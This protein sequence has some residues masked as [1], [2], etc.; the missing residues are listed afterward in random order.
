MRPDESFFIRLH[1]EDCKSHELTTAGF[2]NTTA[3]YCSLH[4][5]HYVVRFLT[6]GLSSAR[7][8][9]SHCLGAFS[10]CEIRAGQSKARLLKFHRPSF[11][12][13]ANQTAKLAAPSHRTLPGLEILQHS[14]K[15][16][17]FFFSASIPRT[18]HRTA[19]R[20]WLFRLKTAQRG[21]TNRTATAL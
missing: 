19:A 5:I 9:A 15:M 1:D 10:I 11:C 4:Y 14:K 12:E 20:R 13:F 18:W 3:Y 2:R 8:A 21:T 16:R 7:R 17:V 6:S